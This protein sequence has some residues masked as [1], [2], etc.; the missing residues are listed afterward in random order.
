[1]DKTFYK[2][3]REVLEG[4]REGKGVK[5]GGGE[6]EMGEGGREEWFD[7]HRLM[8]LATRIWITDADCSGVSRRGR[9]RLMERLMVQAA[10]M[11]A[12]WG[13][14]PRTTACVST[15]TRRER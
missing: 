10:R 1:L 8:H 5:E 6:G 11:S 12:A 9:R 7:M 13:W 3:Y 15:V 14:M 4:K 2:H